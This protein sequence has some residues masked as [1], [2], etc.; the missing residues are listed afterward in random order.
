MTLHPA[1]RGWRSQDGNEQC[2]TNSIWHLALALARKRRGLRA[3]PNPM[4]GAVVVKDGQVIGQG[5]HARY[6]A[7]S[8]PSGPRLADCEKRGEHPPGATIY[9]TLEPCCHHGRQPPCTDA[10]HRRQASP[11]WS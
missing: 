2:Q 9:V 1:P 3:G 7:A 11:E 5:N 10:H 8:T 6:A 4:V